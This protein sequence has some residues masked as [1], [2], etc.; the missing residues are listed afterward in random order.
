MK[1]KNI[2]QLGVLTALYV[3]LS[4]LMKFTVIGNIQID[5]G[6]IVFAIALSYFGVIG[7]FVGVGGCAIESIL[8]SAY[9]FS[10]SWFIANLVIG[11]GCGLT[12]KFCK[13]KTI[14]KCLV[15][16]LFVFLGVG[17]CKTLIECQL[18]S[19]PFEVKIVKNLVASTIDSIGMIIGLSIYPKIVGGIKHEKC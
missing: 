1:T 8:L 14:S 5:L 13:E 4:F 11:I 17:L 15:T 6:Y 18:Y 9:G 3:V 19:I 16:I 10:I 7:S 2:V 12:Y